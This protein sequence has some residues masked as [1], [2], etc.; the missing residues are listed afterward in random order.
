MKTF[1]KIRIK[2][3]LPYKN[4]IHEYMKVKCK[5]KMYLKRCQNEEI[6]RFIAKKID[7][8]EDKVSTSCAEENVRKVTKYLKNLETENGELCQRGMWKLRSQLCPAARDPPTA[9]LNENGDLVTT[10]RNLHKLRKISLT[11]SLIITILISLK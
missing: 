11:Y 10:S 3:R 8:I 2:K 6:K 1:R 4:P 7:T 9:K 5:L